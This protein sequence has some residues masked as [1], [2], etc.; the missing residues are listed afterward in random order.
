VLVESRARLFGYETFV[1]PS[2]AMAETLLPGD[3]FISNTWKYA[4]AGPERGEVVV[5]LYPQDPSIK[6]VKRVVG[7]PGETVRISDGE[8]SVNG[9]RLSE[10]YVL[11]ENNRGLLKPTSLEYRVPENGYFMLG[12]NRDNS[13]DSRF[14]GAV[15]RENLHGSVEFIWWSYERSRGLKKERLGLR[16]K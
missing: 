6:Y 9:V 1:V 5:F 15:P 12:D 2:G 14:W 3:R 13:H 4:H 16:V 10:P 7:L 8:V 11:P